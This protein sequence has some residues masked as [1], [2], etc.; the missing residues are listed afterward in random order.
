MCLYPSPK[1][2]KENGTDPACIS[3][4]LLV[5]WTYMDGLL[6][7]CLFVFPSLSIHAQQLIPSQPCAW[8]RLDIHSKW[9]LL[10]AKLLGSLLVPDFST[11]F[12]CQQW[13]LLNPSS[14]LTPV[15]PKHN[16]I[17]KSNLVAPFLSCPTSLLSSAAPFYC[18]SH[19]FFLFSRIHLSL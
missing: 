19:T 18:H 10:T 13:Y 11:F 3:S 17:Y 12:F 5:H 4:L 2:S 15:I 8:R 7:V 14:P 6:F 1:I 9:R 16:Y